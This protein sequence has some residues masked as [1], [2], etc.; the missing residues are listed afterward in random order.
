MYILT[1]CMNNDK[2]FTITRNTTK[3]QL[4][5]L[6][7]TSKFTCPQCET[8]LRLKIGK[9]V[10]P[11]FAHI[12]LTRCITS[13]SERET[14]THLIGKQHLAE[15]FTRVGCK[16]SVEAYLPKI[17]QRPDLLVRNKRNTFAIEFQCSVIPIDDIEKRN[18]G[19]LR[20]K[21][22]SIWLL[23]TPPN[24]PMNATSISVIKLSK[25]IQAF[26]KNLP[27]SGATIITYDPTTAK[28][29]YISQLIH[30]SGSSFLAKIR[31]LSIEQQT[32]PFAQIKILT[33][34]E[35]EDYWNLFQ[36]KR[37]RYLRNRIQSS[38]FGVK[39]RLLK[40][41]YENKIR[42]EDLPLHIGFPVQDSQVIQAHLVEWQLALISALRQHHIQVRDITETW[43]ESFILTQCKF[44]DL[45]K[46][47]AVITC[48]CR[49]LH[50]LD[51]NSVNPINSIVVS[52]SKLLE[53]FEEVI[54]ANRCE[55]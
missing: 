23:R 50:M 51:Y 19:Y 4:L 16:V 27:S 9:V 18:V 49:F 10:T 47:K 15:F 42:P 11:H 53:L 36:Y 20:L 39:D 35:R 2:M 30:I 37:L 45:V 29:I 44:T 8:P 28:F 26:M 38:P 1:A 40:L 34:E 22:P 43:I 7:N 12:V 48:Y 21:I 6:R 17:S 41:C 3:D 54:V 14:P 46:A 5:L 31:A 24:I 52:E 25:F 13:F 55:N 33:K 32:F